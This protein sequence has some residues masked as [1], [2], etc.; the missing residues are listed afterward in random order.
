MKIYKTNAPWITGNISRIASVTTLGMAF[1]F[2]LA[3][4]VHAQTVV[5]PS[6]PPGLEVPAPN[7]AFL[8]GHAVGTQNYVC[9]PSGHLGRV[10]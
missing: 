10:D 3:Q 6:V 8:V 1:M 5:P 2:A 4:P 7:Q 9:Q